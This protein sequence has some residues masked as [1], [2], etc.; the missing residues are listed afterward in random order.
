MPPTINPAAKTPAKIA[1]NA[2]FIRISSIAAISEPVHAPVPGSGTATNKNKP[3][4][5]YLTIEAECLCALFS[6]HTAILSKCLIFFHPLQH[7][8]NKQKNN[9][10]R[11]QIAGHTDQ[12]TLPE[13]KSQRSAER[14]G[15][16]KFNDRQHGTKK[17][18]RRHGLYPQTYNLPVKRNTGFILHD[19]AA[20]IKYI[21]V[22]YT[23]APIFIKK[24]SKTAAIIKTEQTATIHVVLFFSV[25]VCAFCEKRVRLSAAEIGL[26]KSMVKAAFKTPF[27]RLNGSSRGKIKSITAC[28][29]CSR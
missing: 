13:R 6:T 23:V 29:D 7:E 19:Y 11:N 20:Q 1:G 2:F 15:T 4:P 26:Y 21:H 28:L 22:I 14:N 17:K 10:N 27:P 3:H 18:Y 25:W 12:K 8:T 16:P 5:A 9:R 24:Y